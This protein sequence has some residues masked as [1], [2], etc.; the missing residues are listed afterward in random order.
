MANKNAPSGFTPK[1]HY[2]GG[3]PGRE[4]HYAIASGYASD[5]FHGD[6]VIPLGTTKEI[7]RPA[8]GADRMQGIFQSCFYLD[9][10]QSAPQYN[11]RWPAAQVTVGANPADA[12]IYDDPNI[13][14]ECQVSAASGVGSIGSLIDFLIGTG[15]AYTKVSGD[16]LDSST[17]D[18]AGSAFKIIDVAGDVPNDITSNFA[19]LLVLPN[20]H[21]LKAAMTG[22]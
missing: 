3:I 6:L 4:N 22:I 8:T 14:F 16:T 11:R 1:A 15:N 21:Y 5:I 2:G 19:K 13:L 9:P 20:K 18:G 10:N 7:S 17:I 12:I